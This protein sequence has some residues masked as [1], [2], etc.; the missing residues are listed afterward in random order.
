MK[1]FKKIFL[2]FFYVLSIYCG[3]TFVNILNTMDEFEGTGTLSKDNP[4]LGPFRFEEIKNG[5]AVFSTGE[6]PKKVYTVVENDIVEIG[7]KDFKKG[8]VRVE[9]ITNDSITLSGKI[10]VKKDMTHWLMVGLFSSIFFAF[11]STI[12][13]RFSKLVTLIKKSRSNE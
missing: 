9:K 3:Y 6:R 5:V 11:L 4:V 7:K 8:E 13:D 10:K 2:L 1:V 12:Y